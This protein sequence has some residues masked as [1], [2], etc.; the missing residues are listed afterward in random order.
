MQIQLWEDSVPSCAGDCA[1]EHSSGAVR[2]K[3]VTKVHNSREEMA[4]E[5]GKTRLE[6]G[7]GT[8]RV[9][10]LEHAKDLVL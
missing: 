6:E 5:S 3:R 1:R 7:Q 4:R 10:V 8:E 2:E 9:S